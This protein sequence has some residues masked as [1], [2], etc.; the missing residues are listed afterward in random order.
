MRAR[1]IT[2]RVTLV[3]VTLGLALLLT[4][5]L[6]GVADPFGAVTQGVNQGLYRHEIVAPDLSSP[7]L[8]RH[9]PDRHVQ[10]RGH[11]FRTNALGLRGP[12]LE[13]PKPEGRR[14]AFFLGDSVVLGWG[15]GDED[16]FVHLCEAELEER[17]GEDWDTVNGGHLLHD[18]SQE[19]G[20]LQEVGLAA[21][22]DLVIHV[23]VEN[24]IVSTAEVRGTQGERDPEEMSEEA[25]AFLTRVKWINKLRPYLPNIQAN[26]QHIFI[27]SQ[28]AGQQGSS[29]HA[30]EM[31]LDLQAGWERSKVALRGMRDL[32]REKGVPFVIL[33]YQGGN[34][35]S[36]ALETFCKEESI[37]Y[38]SIAFRPEDYARGIAVSAA[39]AHANPLGHRILAERIMKSMEEL[40]MLE[41]L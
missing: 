4:E 14:R 35:L 19:L 11:V 41:Q 33:D 31:G 27:Q 9:R 12:A 21:D 17:T 3:L 39:D 37:P 23:F 8:F 22:P 25:R 32:C 16:T 29:E 10:M 20:V 36:E 38:D 6:V 24:D 28:P 40:G 1:R 2:I 13:L 26:L 15:V 18:S 30:E 7:R 5:W 34:R